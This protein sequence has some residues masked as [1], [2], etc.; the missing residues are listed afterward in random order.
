MLLIGLEQWRA[1][2]FAVIDID[3]KSKSFKKSF[4]FWSRN[5]QQDFFPQYWQNISTD[6]A[7][8][9]LIQQLPGALWTDR[10]QNDRYMRDMQMSIFAFKCTTGSPIS[11]RQLL[12]K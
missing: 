11:Q 12:E 9:N 4:C 2:V 6:A 5:A 7:L 1:N 10:L 3:K 8:R